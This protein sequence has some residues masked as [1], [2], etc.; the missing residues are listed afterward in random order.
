MTDDILILIVGM[1]GGFG[2]FATLPVLLDWRAR[3]AARRLWADRN[4]RAREARKEARR[5]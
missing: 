4:H 3:R 2:V 1:I 5:G